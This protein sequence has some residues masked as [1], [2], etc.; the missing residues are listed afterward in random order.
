M[1][2]T[3]PSRLVQQDFAAGMFRSVSPELIPAN[4]AWDIE[5]GLL[6]EN[7]L[8][9]RRGGT[10]YKST[11]AAT[12]E[13]VAI[14]HGWLDDGDEHTI[15]A[16]TADIYDMDSGGVIT[17][18]GGVGM[19]GGP[20]RPIAMDGRLFFPGGVT[21]D[22]TTLAAAAEAAPF[23]TVV[24]NRLLAGIP[25]AAAQPA[26]VR[27][28]AILDPDT[29]DPTDLH[30]MAGG[31]DLLGLHGMRDAAA[32]FTT[33]GVWLIRNMAYNLTDPDGNV[34]Q[35]L[36]R[37]STDFVLWGDAGIA[38]WE[39]AIVAPGR[40]A[41][42]IMSLGVASEA[43]VAFAPIS[44][45]IE[46]LYRG[47]VAAGYRPGQAAVHRG[48]YI[49]PILSGLNV[50]DTLV[51]R[52]DAR[53]SNGRPIFPWTRLSGYGAKCRALASIP[54]TAKLLGAAE[55][56][57]ILTLRYFDSAVGN[58][59]DADASVYPW[60]VTLRDYQ[61][62][63]L[64]VN[65][66]LWLRITYELSGGDTGGAFEGTEWGGFDWGDADWGGVFVP[67]PESGVASLQ[68]YMR[69]AS[70]TT[71]WGGFD[72]GGADWGTPT[73]DFMQLT[74]PAPDAPPQ[75]DLARTYRW[76]CGKK[77]R[78]ARFKL[79]CEDGPERL[80]LKAVEV[81]VRDDGRI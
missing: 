5:N 63:P 45:P 60:E 73:G 23:Y 77:V 70:S 13:I 43:P 74:Q 67:T 8:I 48:H 47:Y 30:E 81:F 28:S 62:G 44:G 22:G 52:L 79:R 78:Y 68:A 14:W 38:G 3:L 51:C 36:D 19:P 57:R 20:G 17:N 2:A 72:W 71:E 4:G 6:D 16:T 42:W 59:V 65:T 64:N 56:E 53:A 33:D 55:D 10:E 29:F 66:V 18:L 1:P 61:T 40:D 32:V 37:Y 75:T 34:Q 26:G 25:A 39:G 7:H 9:Y 12:D 50:I 54:T 15:F 24:A 21:Y 58:A 31:V 49:L 69:Q 35:S 46:S 80:A 11:S 41:V 27:F 76:R